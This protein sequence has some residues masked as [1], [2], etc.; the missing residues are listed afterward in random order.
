MR[1][2][3]TTLLCSLES[4]DFTA[5]LTPRTLISR[6]QLEGGLKCTVR[7]RVVAICGETETQ[8]PGT[9]GQHV[10]TALPLQG[11]SPGWDTTFCMA[12]HSTSLPL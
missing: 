11:L 1:R 8:R 4:S 5:I 2:V 6:T 12:A 10:R 7:R 9:H 3:G